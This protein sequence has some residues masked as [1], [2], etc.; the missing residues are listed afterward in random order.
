MIICRETLREKI[1]LKEIVIEPIEDNQIQ[2]A[3]VDLSLADEFLLVDENSVGLID[4]DSEIKYKKIV[5]DEFVLPP[6]SFVLAKTIEKVSIPLNLTAF[7]EGRSSVGRMGLFIQNA[8]W[9]DSGFNG[10]ITLELFNANSLPIKLRAGKR[11]CQLVFMSLD[12][13]LIEG[14]T[15]KYQGQLEVTGSRIHLDKK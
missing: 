14:Y 4:F 7:V 13:E 2:P 12:K 6:K 11:I 8:G 3:S 10:T 5:A 15:G 1:A 9:I